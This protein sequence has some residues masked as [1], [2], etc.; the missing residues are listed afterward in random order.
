MTR[1]QVEKAKDFRTAVERRDCQGG[2]APAQV[3]KTLGHQKERLETICREIEMRREQW[4]QAEKELHQR[5]VKLVN[6][7]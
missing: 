3:L 2:A 6:C 4:K 1:E 7:E 5:A